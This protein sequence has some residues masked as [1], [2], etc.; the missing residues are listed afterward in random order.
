MVTDSMKSEKKGTSGLVL[1]WAS[2]YDLL[3]WFLMR[4]KER[5]F[6]EKFLQLAHLNAGERVLD[7]GCGTGTLAIAAKRHVGP[8]AIVCGIDTSPE[9]IAR[10]KRKAARTGA[11]VDFREGIA[12]APPFPAAYFDVVLSTV[13]LHHLGPKARKECASEIL[14]VL[15]SG[16]PW[17]IVDFEGSAR[18]V[19]GI[20][21]FFHRHGHIR[22]GDLNALVTGARLKSLE[23][24][25]VG[26][27]HLH[28]VLAAASA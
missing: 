16:G 20:L 1:H 27:R 25:P 11:E 13:M 14:R 4:G 24:G 8:F 22:P 21:R 2:R 10:A 7:V 17:F 15:K 5:A 26:L 23:K 19:G 18:H 3:L 6:R 12:E 28:F 9:M